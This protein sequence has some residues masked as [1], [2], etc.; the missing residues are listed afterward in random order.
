[1]SNSSEFDTGVHTDGHD[2]DR[3]HADQLDAA[4]G[5]IGRFVDP[6]GLTPNT[7]VDLTELVASKAAQA[8]LDM[9]DEGD[10]ALVLS[11]VQETLKERCVNSLTRLDRVVLDLDGAYGRRAWMATDVP[12]IVFAAVTSK[13][14]SIQRAG[15]G[16]PV[17][18]IAVYFEPSLVGSRPYTS[19]TGE[20]VQR[21]DVYD[22]SGYI[23]IV[24]TYG[25]VAEAKRDRAELM[26][27]VTTVARPLTD[28]AI[29][30]DPIRSVG[31]VGR[32]TSALDSL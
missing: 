2:I 31:V 24:A 28:S 4:E 25:S 30:D 22:A 11:T 8:G 20:T 3:A 10:R 13:D 7:K 15:N 26:G 14:S 27:A 29:E 6:A 17:R 16:S 32:D 9:S 1:M 19:K 23:S 21:P 18:A 5:I 12:A